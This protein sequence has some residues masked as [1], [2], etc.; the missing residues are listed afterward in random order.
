MSKRARLLEAAGTEV[1]RLCTCPMKGAIARLRVRSI[2]VKKGSSKRGTRA[3]SLAVR[4]ILQVGDEGLSAQKASSSGAT[5]LL[6]RV[7][8]V[9]AE[10]VAFMVSLV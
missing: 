3:I 1:G 4:F 9:R 5:V 2:S 6:A 7:Y 8:A 10:R